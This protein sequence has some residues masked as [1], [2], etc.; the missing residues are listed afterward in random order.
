MKEPL[1]SLEPPEMVSVPRADWD[2]LQAEVRR[3]RRELG[4][5]VV[6]ARI[7]S[8]SDPGDA[9]PTLSRSQLAEAWDIRPGPAPETR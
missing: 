6:T 8:D 5:A 1:V 2:S 7:A 4:Q 3:L 9:A